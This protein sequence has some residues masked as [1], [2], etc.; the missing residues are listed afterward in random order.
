MVNHCHPSLKKKYLVFDT[1]EVGIVG[2]QNVIFIAA[3][4]RSIH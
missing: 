1:T 2:D 3:T 4:K